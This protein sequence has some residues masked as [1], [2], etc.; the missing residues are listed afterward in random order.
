MRDLSGWP[1]RRKARRVC[2][3]T[4][5]RYGGCATH[6]MLWTPRLGL[7]SALQKQLTSPGSRPSSS[8][9]SQSPNYSRSF[10]TASTARCQPQQGRGGGGIRPAR[11]SGHKA[12]VTRGGKWARLAK[13]LTGEL[14][15]DLF[16]HL[17]EFKRRPHPSVEKVP[18]ADFIVYRARRRFVGHRIVPVAVLKLG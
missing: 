11:W 4:A 1:A 5:V 3:V 18:G 14:T 7:G 8:A 2:G 13:I 15:V 16:D 12:V 9:R 17:R 10:V 6:T